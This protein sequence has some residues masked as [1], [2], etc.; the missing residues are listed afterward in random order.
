MF[1]GS[2]CLFNQTFQLHQLTYKSTLDLLA[3][4]SQ[5][6]GAISVGGVVHVIY[7]CSAVMDRNIK[8][9]G[10]DLISTSSP[11]AEHGLC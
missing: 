8:P 5:A 6:N 1:Q 10:S 3:S 2:G 11:L 9:Q 4:W 7:S